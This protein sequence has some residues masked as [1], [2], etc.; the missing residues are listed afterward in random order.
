MLSTDGYPP[1]SRRW[2]PQA[3]ETGRPCGTAVGSAAAATD[4]IAQGFG[5]VVAANDTTLLA[6]AAM[7]LIHQIRHRPAP[8][9]GPGPGGYRRSVRMWL[10]APGA[11]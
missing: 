8:N 5:F 4:A 1:T 7:T 11:I 10:P 2:W 6:S 9:D 3:I